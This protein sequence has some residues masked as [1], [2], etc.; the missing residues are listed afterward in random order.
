MKVARTEMREGVLVELESK[1]I[2]QSNLSPECWYVQVW[3]VE[4][5]CATCEFKDTEECGGENIRK[6]GKNDKGIT[7]PI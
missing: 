4:K 5:G 2:Q 1:T 6:T 3:G 7:V